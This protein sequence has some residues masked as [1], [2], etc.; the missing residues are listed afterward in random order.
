VT[1]NS[2]STTPPTITINGANP[3][4]IQVGDSYADLGATVSDTGQGQA[5]DT[6]LGLKYFGA[7]VS[8]IVLDTSAAATD[9]IDYV[10]TDTLGNTAT[11]TRTVIVEA[12]ASSPPAVSSATTSAAT[13]TTQ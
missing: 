12:Q 4:I 2:A 1:Q 11:S 6:N 10:A 3:A 5:G 7:L 9:T 13:S 8:N